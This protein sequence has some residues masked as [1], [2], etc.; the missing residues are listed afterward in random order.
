MPPPS[1][2]MIQIQSE[3]VSIDSILD[4]IEAGRVRVPKLLRNF[5]WTPPKMTRLFDSIYN[6]Y[7]IGSICLWDSE[8]ALVSLEQLGP[9]TIKTNDQELAPYILDGQQRLT[10]L[11]AA[12]QISGARPENLEGDAWKWWIYFDLKTKEFIHIE[13]GKSEYWQM[14]LNVI[15]RTVDYLKFTRQIQNDMTLIE[16][17]DDLVHRLKYYTLVI[18]RTRGGSIAQAVEMFSRL[19]SSG[20]GLKSDEMITSL[21][22][23][24]GKNAL[25]DHP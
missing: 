20:A 22:Y 7:P 25:K 12:L 24:E 8:K 17:A 19:N 18:V 5:E 2:P 16:R 1:T 11:F 13:N 14:P 15:L 9:F 23:K 6:G 4:G 10:T 21:S 3:I